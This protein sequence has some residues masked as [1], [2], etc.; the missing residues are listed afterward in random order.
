MDCFGYIF[1]AI[2]L[3]ISDLRNKHGTEI[4]PRK[5][6]SK[7]EMFEDDLEVRMIEDDLEVLE[8]ELITEEIKQD[9]QMG[10][11]IDVL[12]DDSGE[13]ETAIPEDNRDVHADNGEVQ[14]IMTDKELEEIAR[15]TFRYSYT[16]F[17]E[18]EID[19]DE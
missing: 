12:R 4:K 5:Y 11:E 14:H 15:S 1:F 16:K 10:T 9:F 8:D 19:D 17:L 7:E 18:H 6:P 13:S 3:K 2:R